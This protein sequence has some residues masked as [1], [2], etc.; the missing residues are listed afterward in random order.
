[1]R[2]VRKIFALAIIMVLMLSMSMTA[3]A[4]PNA[5][6]ES[7]TVTINNLPSTAKITYKQ[8][9]KHVP[10]GG[11]EIISN[12]ADFAKLVEEGSGKEPLEAYADA[13]EKDR[14]NAFA[15]ATIDEGTG[16]AV[17]GNS[18]TVTEAGLYLIVIADTNSE[19]EYKNMIASIGFDYNSNP[20]KLSNCSFDAKMGKT[21]VE[22]TGDNQ[23]IEQME[24][25]TYTVTG[26]IPYI[27]GGT[28]PTGDYEYMV[29]IK[30]V[31]TG[32]EYVAN[33]DA[34]VPV[35]YEILGLPSDATP[36]KGTINLD[37]TKTDDT[38]SIIIPLDQFIK[39][40]GKITNQYA[41]KDVQFTYKAK[42]KSTS[43]L[44]TNTATP[45][46]WGKDKTPTTFKAVIAK[47][48]ITKKAEAEDNQDPT[49]L[50]GAKFA[51]K[52]LDNQYAKFDA[53]KRLVEWVDEID[54]DNADDY[55]VE[56]NGAGLAE[57]YGFDRDQDYT[58]VEY[59]APSGYSIKT[60]EV[61]TLAWEKDKYEVENDP[62]TLI[63]EQIA[64]GSMLD[65]KLIQLPYT[66][67]KGTAAFTIFG[68]VLMSA[69][70]GLYFVNKKN[71]SVK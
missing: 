60:D 42:A 6:P 54:D 70:A 39:I 16:I 8:I 55:T 66:G 30:D 31:L 57:A 53:N 40:D 47:L 68:V 44:V 25:V 65:S 38:E 59:S 1:M 2:R 67:G 22:K 35:T 13:E 63:E 21:K 24:V 23:F 32:G 5:E 62:S 27:P 26:R 58:A 37:V 48:E 19:N 20:A 4:A 11:W 28:A 51:I 69:G 45:N 15:N 18:F 71:K 56:T 3:F 49:P 61:I 12:A 41:N 52:N 46:Y 36:V 7:A 34:T 9:V 50:K 29:S 64:S 33:E 43:L 14:I 17:N 10:T